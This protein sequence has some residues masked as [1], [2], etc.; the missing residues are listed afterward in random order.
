MLKAIKGNKV[1]EIGE[2]EKKR[3]LEDG[4]DIYE[5]GRIKE[6]S[7]KK[8]VKYEEYK[9][10]Q[11]ELVEVK[12]SIVSNEEIIKANDELTQK[13]YE[14]EA[15]LKNQ[16]STNVELVKANDEF[17]KSNDKLTKQIEK[18]K[19]SSAKEE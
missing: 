3:Y 16:K 19:G 12:K 2:K 4:F 9:K 15:E 6:Y 1:Y 11:D 7:P 17:V 10:L 13:V 8:E 14:L 5:N 18:L